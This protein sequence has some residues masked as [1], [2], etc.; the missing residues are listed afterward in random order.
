MVPTWRSGGSSR[1]CQNSAKFVAERAAGLGIEPEL[2][3]ARMVGRWKSG[4][5][6]ELAPLCDDWALGGNPKRNN[7]FDYGGDPYQRRCPYA[8]HIRKVY[9]RDEAPGGETEAQT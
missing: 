7:D 8:A 9:P 6:L 2:L 3:G 5:P 4:A 1:K